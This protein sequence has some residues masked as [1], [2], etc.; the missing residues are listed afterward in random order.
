MAAYFDRRQ[1]EWRVQAFTELR[2][3]VRQ[4][5]YPIPDVCVYEEPVPEEEV[6][7]RRPLLW[8]EILS[9]DD[10]L[11]DVWRRADELVAHG[12]PYVWIIDRETLESELRTKSGGQNVPDK[13]L[14]PEGLPIVIPLREVI[15]ESP[16][17]GHARP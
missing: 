16:T 1:R 7:S 17:W 8:I 9:G 6:A 3:R 2:I 14:R 10:R 4:D 15:E 5:W 11:T 12:V 13:T